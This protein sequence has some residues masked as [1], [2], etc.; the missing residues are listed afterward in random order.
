MI[1]QLVDTGLSNKQVLGALTI[2]ACV[3][4]AFAAPGVAPV[5]FHGVFEGSIG[6]EPRGSFGFGYDPVFVPLGF[7]Q[8]L[9]ELSPAQKNSMSHR[10]RALAAFETWAKANSGLYL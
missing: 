2:V 9:A 8:T 4:L 10:A 6:F 7:S 5:V 3:A 1:V